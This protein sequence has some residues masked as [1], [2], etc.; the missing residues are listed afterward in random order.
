M[1]EHRPDWYGRMKAGPFRERTFTEECMKE[2]GRKARDGGRRSRSGMWMYAASGLAVASVL[3]LVLVL[4]PVGWFGTKPSMTM[5]T[6][7]PQATPLPTEGPK[8]MVGDFYAKGETGLYTAPNPH[9]K[10]AAVFTV[11]TGVPLKVLDI[12]GGYAKVNQDGNAGW[13]NAWYLTKEKDEAP[14]D[15]VEPYL[16]F[17]GSAVTMSVNPE[18]MEPSGPEVAPGKVVKVVKEFQDW[19]G[20]DIVTYD[21][22]Y[23]GELWLRKSELMDWDPALAMEGVLRQG[24]VIKDISGREIEVPW[25]NSVFVE[26]KMANGRYRIRSEDGVAGFVDGRDFV[27]NPFIAE[28]EKRRLLLSAMTEN[29]LMT[30]EEIKGYERYAASR[31]ENLLRGLSPIQIFRYYV[32]AQLNRDEKTVYAL[33]IQDEGFTVPDYDTYINEISND[34]GLAQRTWRLWDRLMMGYR[35]GEEVESGQATITIRPTFGGTVE[36]VRGF[37][38]LRNKAGI[39]KVAWL[40][41]Q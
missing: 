31:D 19:V 36:D 10:E 30:S 2:I 38:L 15:A 41:M 32:Q 39:W 18:E 5:P 34:T 29:W 17:A 28:N 4:Q 26:E 21:Q 9:T 40:P 37:Q 6:V 11:K 16:M 3:A 33:L 8:P 1:S 27:P 24:A 13:M 35:L 22:P 7:T 23:G 20:V 14:V 25:F 12:S